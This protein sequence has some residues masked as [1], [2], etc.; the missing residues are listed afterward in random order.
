MTRTLRPLAALAM[1]AVIGAG[2]SNAPAGS[3]SGGNS[4]AATHA[5]AVKFAECMRNNGVS[6]FP[7]PDASG[8]LTIDAVANGS[9]LDTDTAAFKQAMSACK[10]LEPPGFTGGKVTDQQMKARLR[11]AQCIRE[12]GVKDFPDP[13]NDEPLVDTRKIPSAAT[14]GGMSILNAAMRKCR[15][16]AAAGVTGGR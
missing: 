15:D 16:F 5:K 6:A 14:E 8:E 11:F 2:C 10:D 1:I 4:T 13:A 7:D 9:S 3:G 12:N